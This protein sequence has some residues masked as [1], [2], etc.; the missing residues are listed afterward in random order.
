[1]AYFTKPL[2]GRYSVQLKR[3]SYSNSEIVT[4]SQLND[5]VGVP[6]RSTH[7]DGLHKSGI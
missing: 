6:K 3:R 2:D 5:F 1:M 4:T 7:H